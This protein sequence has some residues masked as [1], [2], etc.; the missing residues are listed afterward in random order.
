MKRCARWDKWRCLPQLFLSSMLNIGLAL[1]V[2][3]IVGGFAIEY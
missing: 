1:S 3:V 2:R